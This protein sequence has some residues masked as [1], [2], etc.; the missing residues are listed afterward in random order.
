MIRWLREYVPSSAA[1]I[2][3]CAMSDNIAAEMP[4]VRFV[5]PCNFCPYMRK[6]TLGAVRRSLETSTYEVTIDP[7]VAERAKRAID[8]MLDVGRGRSG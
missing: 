1:L 4:D 6:I 2:T 3:E 7:D 5:R 8:R